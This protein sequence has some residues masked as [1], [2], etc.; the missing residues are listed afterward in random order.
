MARI[1]DPL[2]A[3]SARP[4]SIRAR[5]GLWR[6]DRT[7]A[8]W[9]RA[10][11]LHPRLHPWAQSAHRAA[12]RC[13]PLPNMI[14]VEP[15][16]WVF[17]APHLNRRAGRCRCECVTC[18][19]CSVSADE[20]CGVDTLG[21]PSVGKVLERALQTRLELADVARTEV[22]R[23][24][25]RNSGKPSSPDRNSPDPVLAAAAPPGPECADGLSRCSAS[26]PRPEPAEHEPLVL[27]VRRG[28]YGQ[29][30]RRTVGLW[31]WLARMFVRMRSPVR[32]SARFLAIGG[33]QDGSQRA[34][35][36][37]TAGRRLANVVAGQPG[38]WRQEA[39]LSDPASV[40]GMQEVRGSNPRSSTRKARSDKV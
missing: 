13:R 31:Q 29:L 2:A 35:A 30:L 9:Q 37:G 8:R 22:P 38:T 27:G 33:S 11:C 21:E 10:L 20:G 28:G 16:I 19:A 40:Y 23:S 17:C 39:P 24:A 14:A 1:W 18:L 34:Q 4:S 32:F 3:A 25:S 26:P 7:P 6:G 15:Q 12:I 36:P 5:I